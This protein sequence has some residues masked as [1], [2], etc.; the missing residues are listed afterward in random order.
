MKFN[1][2][3]LLGK[4]RERGLTQEQLAKTIGIS[5][6]TFSSKINNQGYFLSKEIY[7]ICDVLEISIG[8]VGDYFFVV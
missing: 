3:K 2:S 7:S 8:D 6:T 4:I 1:H 5:K